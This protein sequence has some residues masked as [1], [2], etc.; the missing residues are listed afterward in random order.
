M[1]PLDFGPEGPPRGGASG[2]DDPPSDPP[3]PAPP[4]E[5]DPP[6]PGGTPSPERELPWSK[7]RLK[8]LVPAFIFV[9]G[10]FGLQLWRGQQARTADPPELVLSGPTMG[11]RYNIKVVGPGLDA[12]KQAQL[13]ADLDA[14]LSAVL[15]D[16]STYDPQSSLSRFNQSRSVDPQAVPAPLLTVV[17]LSQAIH[18]ASDGAFDVTVG[19]LVNA[20]GFGPDQRGNPPDSAAR[21]RLRAFVGA[22]KLRVDTAAGTLQKTHPQLYVDLSAI[23]KGYGVDRVADAIEAAGYTHY[24][25]EIGGEVRA[26]GLN[27]AG[28]PWRIGVER[29]QDEGS[30]VL[31]VVRPGDGAMATSGDYRNF[32]EVE[33]RR[34]SHTIDPRTGEPIAHGLASVTVFHA[35]CAE[36]DAWATA[37]NVL[38]PVAGPAKAEQQG[39]AALFLVRKPDGTF[40]AVE[41]SRFAPYKAP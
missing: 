21:D 4:P 29:P 20:W 3:A 2:G 30:S 12:A 35:R 27:A 15:A 24:M 40:E 37:L 18:Q 39:L 17:A 41:T 34:F 6:P 25:V 36:A 31:Q 23:A 38:G 14:A 16:M 22:D 28:K 7:R 11:T 1:P 33:G 8:K 13:Q 9:V 5:R 32:I 26:R 19:P 10:L